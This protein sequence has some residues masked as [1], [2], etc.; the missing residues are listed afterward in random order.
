LPFSGVLKQLLRAA[1]AKDGYLDL[2]DVLVMNFTP[3][4]QMTFALE[5]GDILVTEGC[6]SL[7]QIGANAVWNTDLPG[8]VCFQNTLLRLRA[9]PGKTTPSFLRHWARFAFS[10]GL[11]ARVATGTNVFHIGSTRA[12]QIRV[13]CPNMETQANIT[14]TLDA[15]EATNSGIQRRIE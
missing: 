5:P 13:S 7:S 8:T 3:A 1:N 12:K 10:S 2:T 6:G 11:F 4:E 14:E 9:I 15:C